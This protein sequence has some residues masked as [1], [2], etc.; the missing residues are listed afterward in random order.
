MCGAIPIPSTLSASRNFINAIDYLLKKNNAIQI[1]P[2]C[3]IWPYFI[4]IRPF[5]ATS[6]KYPIRFHSPIFVITNTFH[7]RKLTKI[8]KVITYID[9][10]IFPNKNLTQKEQ[11][12]DLCSRVTSIM[13][14]RAKNT[15][16]SYY[17]YIKEN[18]NND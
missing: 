12:E 10:P 11:E 2:E 8:P 15:N 9:G 14:E 7:K 18:N 16:Y 13:K 3:H 6:F 17:T 1:Y 5:P 4:G